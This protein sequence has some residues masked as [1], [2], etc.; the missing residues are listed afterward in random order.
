MG[1]RNL[2]SNQSCECSFKK[3]K[4]VLLQRA[5]RTL[6]VPSEYTAD[7]T[8]NVPSEYT[9]GENSGSLFNNF[10]HSI[11]ISS[12]FR[13][14]IHLE[15]CCSR[16]KIP[17]DYTDTV[18]LTVLLGVLPKTHGVHHPH[19]SVCACCNQAIAGRWNTSASRY[20]AC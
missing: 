4:A 2:S 15:V 11:S 19:V 20:G 16:I 8:L 5:D 13:E 12:V 6:N 7:R 14:F 10:E 18:P 3:K 17:S 9:Y 1:V